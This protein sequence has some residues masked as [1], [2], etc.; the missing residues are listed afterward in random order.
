MGSALHATAGRLQGLGAAAP[1]SLPSSTLA[2]LS[3]PVQPSAARMLG[4]NPQTG[5]VG[6]RLIYYCPISKYNPSPPA[7]LPT[8]AEHSSLRLLT[9]YTCCSGQRPEVF[10]F[11][12]ETSCTN[13][14]LSCAQTPQ[15][16]A[17]GNGLNDFVPAFENSNTRARWRQLQAATAFVVPGCWQL[18]VLGERGACGFGAG[19]LQQPRWEAARGQAEDPA[20]AACT[21]STLLL[22]IHPPRP[23]ALPAEDP[24]EPLCS[25][26]RAVLFQVGC[27]AWLV[28][29]KHQSRQVAAR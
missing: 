12:I 26:C 2:S 10:V 28:D 19:Q 23:P 20:C 29:G 25:C 9:L 6:D 15:V 16:A 11:T 3:S 7:C 13:L 27:A 1:V 24:S 8:P 21:P 18:P 22:V 17:V 4:I 14:A 5:A